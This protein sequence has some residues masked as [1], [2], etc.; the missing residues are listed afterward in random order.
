MRI[1]ASGNLI[2]FFLGQTLYLLPQ[3]AIYWAET[4]TLIVADIHIGKVNHFRKAGIAVPQAVSD[5]D[6]TK[7]EFI[8]SSF[9]ISR[10]LILGDLFHSYYNDSTITFSA[11]VKKFPAI[12]FIL[13]K[14]NHDVL[15]DD[16]YISASLKVYK[17]TF[18]QYPFIFSH[19][20]LTQT[21]TY[22]NLSGHLHPAVKLEGKAKQS[23]VL[24]CYYFG[25]KNGILPAFSN[26]TGKATLPVKKGD[27][28]FV[29]TNES[30]ISINSG[31]Q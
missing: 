7:L 31:L 30:V 5:T 24:P 27:T 14:G 9:S 10:V 11:W 17:E 26:F 25:E 13:I 19:I 12:E 15:H 1:T 22:Y 2:H 20:P 6:Y 23:L 3:K 28:L 21:S 4:S 18:T 16:F 8:L 29:I